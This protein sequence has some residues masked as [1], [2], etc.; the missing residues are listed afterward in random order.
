MSIAGFAIKNL[1]V[2]MLSSILGSAFVAVPFWICWNYIAPKFL[3]FLPTIYQ[4]F[5]YLEVVAIFIGLTVL[6]EQIQKI[7]PKFFSVSK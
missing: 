4:S 3:A 7:T 6:G 1:L 5:Q 2:E